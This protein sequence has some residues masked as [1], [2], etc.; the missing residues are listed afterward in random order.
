M[1]RSKTFT[2]EY[3]AVIAPAK[4]VFPQ[5]SRKACRIPGLC[6]GMQLV[7]TDSAQ[8]GL[9]INRINPLVQFQ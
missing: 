1:H 7:G 5:N 9:S 4:A 6:K 8:T 2:C 3:D